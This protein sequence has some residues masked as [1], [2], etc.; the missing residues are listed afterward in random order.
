MI[1]LCTYLIL[2]QLAHMFILHVSKEVEGDEGL[3]RASSFK[4]WL[5][6]STVGFPLVTYAVIVSLIALRMRSK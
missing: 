5:V 1:Y 4:A 6:H 3:E 2:N